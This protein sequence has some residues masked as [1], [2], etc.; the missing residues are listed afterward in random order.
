[1]RV[2]LI[3]HG[4]IDASGDTG[5]GTVLVGGDAHGANPNVQNARQTVIGSD[6]IIRADAGTTG[7]AAG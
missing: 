6:G 2:G 5:G 3:G 7:T 4:V 1:V